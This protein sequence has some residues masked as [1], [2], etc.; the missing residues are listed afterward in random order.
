MHH[1]NSIEKNELPITKES[2]LEAKTTTTA[3]TEAQSSPPTSSSQFAVCSTHGR[4]RYISCLRVDD[5]T[6]E[7]VCVPYDDCTTL[8]SYTKTMDRGRRVANTNITIKS[9]NNNNNNNN[10]QYVNPKVKCSLHGIWRNARYMVQ[11]GSSQSWTCTA[12]STCRV[13]DRVVCAVHHKLRARDMMERRGEG[14]GEGYVCRREHLCGRVENRSQRES[15]R[16]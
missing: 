14:E 2:N 9:N 1:E 13:T 10:N 11:D 16:W 3:T 7:L 15:G 4:R 8:S 5:T 6:K 12:G